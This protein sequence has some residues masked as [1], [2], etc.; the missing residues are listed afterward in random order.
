MAPACDWRT[1][2]LVTF[3]KFYSQSSNKFAIGGKSKAMAD[4]KFNDSS[5][6]CVCGGGGGWA[7]NREGVY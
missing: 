5:S 6:V 3:I 1:W 4:S 2:F 7:V